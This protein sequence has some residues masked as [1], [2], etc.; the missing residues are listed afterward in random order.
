L[1]DIQKNDKNKILAYLDIH[2]TSSR[3]SIFIYGPYFPLHNSLYMKVRTIPKL[4]SERTE[5]FRFFS[6]GFKY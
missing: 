3:K 4:I 6:S 5:M 2:A 1:R